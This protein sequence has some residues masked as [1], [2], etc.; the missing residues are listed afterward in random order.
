VIPERSATPGRARDIARATLMNPA[1]FAPTTKFPGEP[2]S[3]A[4]SEAELVDVSHDL[5]ELGVRLFEPPRLAPRVLLHLER[6][7]GH[8][9]R[10]GRLAGSEEHSRGGGNTCT[11]SGV[12]GMFAP[13]PTA[14]Q[15]VLTSFLASFP[16]ISV[17]VWRRASP[18]RR[19]NIQI[20]PPWTYLACLW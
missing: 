12:V 13:S 6:R 5:V 11:P 7:G 18:R 1:M 15:A 4:A 10:V 9:A 3:S 8:A 14:M 2:N 16:V 17:L 20:W 19:R